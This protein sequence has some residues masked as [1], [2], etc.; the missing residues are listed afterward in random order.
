MQAFI[1]KTGMSKKN[2]I[3][4]HVFRFQH[5]YFIVS[6]FPS[7]SS[8][9]RYHNT[10]T[11]T[12][13]N[14]YIQCLHLSSIMIRHRK[15]CKSLSCRFNHYM[16]STQTLWLHLLYTTGLSI[17]SLNVFWFDQLFYLNCVWQMDLLS[18]S[19]KYVYEG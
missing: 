14:W 18:F 15:K 11:D 17:F 12:L 7:P 6:Y 19:V 9:N 13:T 1:K 3:I 4:I 8:Q 10:C 5:Y 16:L 2:E